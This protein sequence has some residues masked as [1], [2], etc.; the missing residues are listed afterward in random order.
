MEKISKQIES[1]FGWHILKIIDSKERKEVTYDEVKKQFENEL[2]L[3]KGREA[4][5]DL[6]D[7]LEDLLASGNTFKEI[8]K[9]LDVK[10]IVATKIDNNGIKQNKNVNNEFQDE[11][12]L[13]TI[14]NQKINEEG[15]IIDIDKDEGLAISLV[16]EIIQPRQLTFK[17]SK[18]SAKEKLIFDLKSN[19]FLKYTDHY[20]SIFPLMQIT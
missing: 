7:E 14:F 16:T 8:S 13:R 11:R 20:A 4:V 10:M 17:E 18:D 1:S 19:I 6:Q 15:N 5:F 3:E 9:I 2:L 12:I